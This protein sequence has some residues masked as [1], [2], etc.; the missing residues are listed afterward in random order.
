MA[1]MEERLEE[2]SRMVGGLAQQQQALKNMQTE[3]GKVLQETRD[4]LEQ[5]AALQELEYVEDFK[6]WVS[7]KK[8]AEFKKNPREE[9]KG[10]G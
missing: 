3:H 1:T 4:E 9:K 8:L 5:L 7:K 10:D 6:M 2:I